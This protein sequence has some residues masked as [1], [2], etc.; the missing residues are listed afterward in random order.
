MQRGNWLVRGVALWVLLTTASLTMADTIYFSGD[1]GTDFFKGEMSYDKDKKV[2]SITLENVQ[3]SQY[4]TAFVFNIAGNAKATLD[5][6]SA[7]NFVGLQNHSAAPYGTFDAGAAIGGAWNGGGN[8]NP[9]ISQGESHT[10][11][12][13]IEILDPDL[14]LDVQ[15]F[16]SEFSTGGSHSAI[17]AV[18]FRGGTSAKIPGDFDELRITQIVPLPAGGWG[19]LALLGVIGAARL[20]RSA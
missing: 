9:G 14:E 4:I 11:L 18:R 2:L 15:D 17:F 6:S 1:N 7:G 5:P 8:P 16:F 13:N 3:S 10:F 20:R 12:F 19:G